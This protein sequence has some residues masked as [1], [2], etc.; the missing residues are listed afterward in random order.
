MLILFIDD[1]LARHHT[2]EKYL[3]KDHVILHACDY[4][5]AIEALEGCQ[6]PI[7][8][9]MFDHDLGDY[10]CPKCGIKLTYK[11]S[12]SGISDHPNGLCCFDC[13][14]KYGDEGEVVERTGNTI[15]QHMICMPQD[16]LPA[17]AIV[18]SHNGYRA[19]FMFE[20]LTK[21]GIHTKQVP[22]SVEMI[23]ALVEDLVEQ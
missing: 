8:L 12:E 3:G 1:S 9:A 13:H 17:T 7:G 16:K 22:F 10:K 6:K 15:I 18:H 4:Q 19:K 21:A 11:M 2:V 5:E 20:D 14:W 23:K